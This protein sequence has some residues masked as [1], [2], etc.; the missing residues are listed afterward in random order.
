MPNLR[1][2]SPVGH[3]GGGRLYAARTVDRRR[4]GQA[5]LWERQSPQRGEVTSTSELIA[6][7]WLTTAVVG[8][9]K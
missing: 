4:P 7:V 2:T 9:A 8:E 5:K 1:G 6:R 3:D